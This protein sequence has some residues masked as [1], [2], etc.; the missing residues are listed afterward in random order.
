VAE[1]RAFA[2]QTLLEPILPLARDLGLGTRGLALLAAVAIARGVDGGLRW[3]LAGI[4]PAASPAQLQ[5]ALRGLGDADLGAFQ[6]RQGLSAT[7][8]L[9]P[10]THARLHAALRALGERSPVP[11][12]SGAQIVQTLVRQA[13]NEPIRH[14][15][16]KLAH[17]PVLE[18]Q[19][20]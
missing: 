9:D 15:L 3:A 18:D 5:A 8:E 11:T 19:P 13:A 20:L 7:G 12:L 6:R 16:E 1:Q 4:G 14:K 17:S 2:R 10:R